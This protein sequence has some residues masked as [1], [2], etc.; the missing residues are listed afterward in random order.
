MPIGRRAFADALRASVRSLDPTLPLHSVF[1]LDEVRVPLDWVAQMWGRCCRRWRRSRWSWPCSGSTASSPTRSRSARTR[2]ACA[3]RSA[4]TAAACCAW[5]CGDGLRLA[6]QAAALGLVGAI[7]LTRSLSQ[8]LYGVGAL[9]PVTF[10]AC[11]L[12]LVLVALVASGAPAWRGT[13]VDPVVAL[14]AE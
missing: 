11:S 8:L 9:D 13:R 1:T 10:A 7:A 4:P 6:L 3:W 5:C 2:S 14:R 12:A